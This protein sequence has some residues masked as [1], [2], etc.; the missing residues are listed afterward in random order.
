MATERRKVRRPETKTKGLDPVMAQV[1][2]SPRA[3]QPRG[4]V[5]ALGQRRA[6]PSGVL[7]RFL[8]V[9][10]VAATSLT[11]TALRADAEL[12]WQGDGNA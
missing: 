10:M 8:V 12:S 11:V 7:D 6:P 1:P 4:V 5:G 3:E 9:F 2:A